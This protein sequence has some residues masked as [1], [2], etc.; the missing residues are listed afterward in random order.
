MKFRHQRGDAGHLYFLELT[1]PGCAFLD[2]DND[3]WQDIFL[4]QSGSSQPTAT[5]KNRPHCALYHNNRD[6]TFSDV[7]ANS[8]FDTDLGYGHGAAVGDFDN[9]G[10]ED[11]F[12]TSYGGNRLFRNLQGSGRF[13]DVTQKM[14]LDKAHGSNYS[15]SAAWGDYDS[16][17]K[18][19][20]YVCYYA[21]WDQATDIK[22]GTADAPDYCH[23][24]F[25]EPI[26]DQ[27]FHNEGTR[28]V[29]VSKKSGIA[30][31]KGRGL[32]V[33]WVD[34][35][36]DGKPDIFVAN[37]MTTLML[38]R[39][40]GNGKFTDVAAQTG[41]A[42]DS[43]GVNIAGMGIAVGDYDRTGRDS[44]YVTNDIGQ[45]NVLFKNEHD[46]FDEVSAQARLGMVHLKYLSWG[47]EFFD[48]DA[49]G[50]RDL[51]INN[52]AV[53]LRGAL[54]RKQLLH[55]QGDG[56]FQE[57][58]DPAQLGD[59]AQ[60][61]RGRGLAVGDYD[62][63]GRL[64]ILAMNQN[65]PAQLLHNQSKSK[66]HWVSFQTIGT[67]SNRDGVHTRLKIT[68]AASQQ[69]ASVRGGSSYLSS[70]DRR[71]YFGLGKADKIDQLVVQWPSGT[72][73]VL[74]NLAADTFYTLTEGRGISQK[75]APA[76]AK[77]K[78]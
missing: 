45:S 60:P 18:L 78:T 22:C 33:A 43:K 67:K 77:T 63:D 57:I 10:Y 75:R 16:D 1:A 38:W 74:K 31:G 72:R 2:Y 21:K 4:V 55:N 76:T 71:V 30:R 8:G 51:I 48:Y 23:P 11:I 47:C 64:D 36:E 70:S 42:Y 65:A 7:T 52:G 27:L 46:T 6:G 56:T 44:L 9:D 24:K 49:D 69:S 15:T 17:G 58:T 66:N 12:L 20:L 25:Y 40:D 59:L 53:V 19:D 50:W 73:E 62:N 68:T 61:R 39:N 5:V 26:E 3:G 54:Q 13:Q 34:Y 37:D 29:D 35:N 28:F 41:S 14:G 32:A